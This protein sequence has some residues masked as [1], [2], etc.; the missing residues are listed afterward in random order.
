M[1]QSPRGSGRLCESRFIGE[2]ESL[3]VREKNL[4][5]WGCLDQISIQEPRDPLTLSLQF[6]YPSFKE[7]GDA[8]KLWLRAE[9]ILPK[10]NDH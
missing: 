4:L 8:Y 1:C 6:F 9:N 10:I 7:K 5:H 3:L 2:M